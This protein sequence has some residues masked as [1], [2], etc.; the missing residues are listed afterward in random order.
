MDP[1]TL[2]LV[3]RV[4]HAV[5]TAPNPDEVRRRILAAID[6]EVPI[7]YLPEDVKQWT[8]WSLGHIQRLCAAR[9]LPHLPGH[10]NRFFRDEVEETLRGMQVGGRFRKKSSQ[11]K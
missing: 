2:A 6:G 5:S 8:G 4:A 9:A 11:T 10:P 3:G 7:V 1:S